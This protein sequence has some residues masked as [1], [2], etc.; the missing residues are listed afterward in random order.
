VTQHDHDDDL[1]PKPAPEETLPETG[2][3]IDPDELDRLEHEGA[4]DV[5]FLEPDRARGD[6]TVDDEEAEEQP[7]PPDQLPEGATAADY[8]RE[9]AD[10]EEETPPAERGQAHG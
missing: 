2:E 9:H 10:G 8:A 1:P 5:E 3:P 6:E 4:D 7:H